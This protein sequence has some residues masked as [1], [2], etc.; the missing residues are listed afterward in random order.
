MEE[1]LFRGK[2][3]D[4]GEWVEGFYLPIGE[5]AHIICEAETEC[6]DGEN[7]DLYAT[8]WYEVDPETV[9]QYTGL[10]DKNGRK[11][12]EGDICK[13]HYAN[14]KRNE[15]VETIVFNGGR[16]CAYQDKDGCKSWAGLYNGVPHLSADKS[17]YMDEIEVIGNIY[18]NSELAEGQG[19]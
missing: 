1:I 9:C 6:I 16:F 15:F 5:K 18:D 7:T 11:I 17:V 12:F 8:E 14:A 10:T 3:V 2:R 13:T 19:K 4:N